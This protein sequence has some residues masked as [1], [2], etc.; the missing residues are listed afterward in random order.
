[1]ASSSAPHLSQLSCDPS[2]RPAVL[3]V[4]HEKS[5]ALIDDDEIAVRYVRRVRQVGRKVE[6]PGAIGVD[7]I[8][9]GEGSAHQRS[10]EPPGFGCGEDRSAVEGDQRNRNKTPVSGGILIGE[11]D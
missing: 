5:L 8:G 4:Q 2:S 7:E 6:K 1:M 11:F 3:I 10:F 9:A